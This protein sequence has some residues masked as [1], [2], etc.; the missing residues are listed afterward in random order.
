MFTDEQVKQYEEFDDNIKLFIDDIVET[1]E[2]QHKE[3]VDNLVSKL[4]ESEKT[5]ESRKERLAEVIDRA[6]EYREAMEMTLLA[7]ENGGKYVKDMGT[8]IK[9]ALLHPVEY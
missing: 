3:E 7:I 9:K 2:T 1:L 6:Y 8:Y 5:S 4:K